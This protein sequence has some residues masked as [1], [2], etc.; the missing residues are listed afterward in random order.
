L[1]E[2]GVAFFDKRDPVN[3]WSIPV[4]PL[5]EYYNSATKSGYETM[6]ENVRDDKSFYVTFRSS[7]LNGST[8]YGYLVGDV[9][10]DRQKNSTPVWL[11]RDLRLREQK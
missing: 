1:S 2:A 6:L 11:L 8:V 3:E 4:E 9:T 5:S 7:D 10:F